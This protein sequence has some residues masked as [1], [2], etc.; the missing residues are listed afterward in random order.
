MAG[1]TGIGSAIFPNIIGRIS[2]VKG[3]S[4]GMGTCALYLMGVL[5]II[6]VI[7]KMKN[8]GEM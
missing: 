1:S 4:V 3:L 2:D 5:T 6:L 7:S 8:P